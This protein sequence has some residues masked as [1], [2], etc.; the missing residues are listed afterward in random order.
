MGCSLL[1][2]DLCGRLLLW[3]S[4]ACRHRNDNLH[5][6]AGS[7]QPTMLLPPLSNHLTQ[8]YGNLEAV[9]G[10]F[11]AVD[12]KLHSQP[13][14]PAPQVLPF[15]EGAVALVAAGRSACHSGTC[16][17]QSAQNL[18]A[19][20]GSNEPCPQNTIPIPGPYFTLSVQK[21]EG[22][23]ISSVLAQ[24]QGMHQYTNGIPS[25][26]RLTVW[27]FAVELQTLVTRLIVV[28]VIVHAYCGHSLS[29]S[30]PGTKALS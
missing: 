3:K 10:Q 30:L 2:H 4:A 25:L 14:C 11:R 26:K 6:I 21:G 5:R 27:A 29:L 22:V 23:K 20:I 18:A 15:P 13:P 28:H 8:S 12:V 9:P 7:P 24:F 16:R 1:T 19:A 17:I